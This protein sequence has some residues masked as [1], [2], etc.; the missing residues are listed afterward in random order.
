MYSEASPIH[1][2]CYKLSASGL[3]LWA[4]LRVARRRLSVTDWSCLSCIILHRPGHG[5]NIKGDKCTENKKIKCFKVK[6]EWSSILVLSSK[7]ENTYKN[8]VRNVFKRIKG[9]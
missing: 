3:W 5:H 4:V 8:K 7:N 1:V 2:A 9:D 6:F